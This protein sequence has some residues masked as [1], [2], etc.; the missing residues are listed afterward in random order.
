MFTL[1]WESEELIRRRVGANQGG[2]A[3]C[4]DSL[5]HEQIDQSIDI[6]VDA[7]HEIGQVGSD[8]VWTP[9]KETHTRSL[10][11]LAWPTS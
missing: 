5:V 7:R 9:G 2:Q 8:V 1:L 3:I 11:S 10:Y 6:R 4:I